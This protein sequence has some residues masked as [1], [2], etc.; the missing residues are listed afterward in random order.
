MI[1]LEDP[2]PILCQGHLTCPPPSQGQALGV[3]GRRSG[4]LFSSV[5]YHQPSSEIAGEVMGT[6]WP[7]RKVAAVHGGFARAS[8]LGSMEKSE[9]GN[10]LLKAHSEAVAEAAMEPSY[11]SQPGALPSCWVASMVVPPPK[12]ELSEMGSKRA[13]G[14][15][16]RPRR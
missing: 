15:V 2:T 5:W 9:V 13:S 14:P 3:R 8:S 6:Q 7:L 11:L 12:A 4:L 10:D 16:P 1:G